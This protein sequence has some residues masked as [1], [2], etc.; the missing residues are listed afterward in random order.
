MGAGLSW[1]KETNI[2]S[3]FNGSLESPIGVFD[4]GVG[5]LS[6]L[7][8]IKQKLPA[9]PL[10]YFGDTAHVPYGGRPLDEIRGFALEICDFLVDR[11]AKMIVMACNISS[12][13]AIDEARRRFPEIPIVGVIEPGSKA[14]IASGA[15]RIGVLAT[16]GTVK[17]GAYSRVLEGLNPDVTVAEVAC[18]DF[19]PIVEAELVDSADAFRAASEYLRP[20]STFGAA[21]VIL[22]CTHY[23]FLQK[24]L[25]A[26]ALDIFPKDRQPVFIDPAI[27]T[28]NTVVDVLAST[29]CYCAA[30]SPVSCEYFVSGSVDSFRQNGSF[31]LGVPVVSVLHQQLP[32]FVAVR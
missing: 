28:A 9:E 6:V 10:L 1:L 27:E 5:G 25:E 2:S 16:L 22:G 23:P 19:V 11:G 4:S 24:T 20:L 14:A 32:T 18:P 31:F 8:Q 26:A 21:S 12:A 13:V 3:K 17:S 29:R 15:V 7:R 30:K